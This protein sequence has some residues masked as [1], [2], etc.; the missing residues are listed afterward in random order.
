MSARLRV[1][2]VGAG[3][4][5]HQHL[6]G[7]RSV[8]SDVIDVTALCDPREEVLSDVADR[9]GVPRRFTRAQALIE[10]GEVD[11]L[12]LLTPPG[13]RH[14]IIE[15]A[16]AASLPLLIEKP[17]A[18]SGAD[19]VGFVEAAESAGVT[20]AV[21]QNFRWFPEYQW[22]DDRLRTADAGTIEYLEARSFQDRPQARGVWRAQERKLEMAIYSVHLIDRLHWLARRE[23]VSVSAVTRRGRDESLEGEQFT[24]LT[25]EF[26]GGVVARMTSS[27][28]SLGLPL[29]DARVDTSRGSLRVTR[30]RPMEGAAE[31]TADLGGVVETQA[32]D[33]DVRDPRMARS[34]GLSGRE[35]AEAVLAGRQPSHSGRD[36]LRTMGIME[37]AYLS[38]ARGGAPV[39]VEEALA[40]R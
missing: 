29:Q 39:A 30:E 23:P 16:L 3:W 12:V 34:Y 20:L 24:T 27:W 19:A 8:A 18:G 21:S 11:A 17:F 7:Y 5:A 13:V 32:F 9:F 31:A 6:A 15:P 36:N 25:V 40:R 10:S 38:A 22:L 14:E 2:L 35:F 26:E 28:K 4:V 33:D 37:A 1:G